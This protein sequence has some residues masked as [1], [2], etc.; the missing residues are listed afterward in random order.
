MPVSGGRQ[1]P[2]Q[3]RL[4]RWIG[5]RYGVND[6]PGARFDLCTSRDLAR[7]AAAAPTL[8]PALSRINHP[9]IKPMELAARRGLSLPG[10][11][12]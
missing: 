9:M 12:L 4:F 2:I 11:I 1:S 7:I 10:S 6:S 5:A 3:D 8:T